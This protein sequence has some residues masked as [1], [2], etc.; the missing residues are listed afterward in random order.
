MYNGYIGMGGAMG[1]WGDRYRVDKSTQVEEYSVE[2]DDAGGL[3]WV[4]VDYVAA[5]YGVAD[6]DS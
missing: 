1:V 3:E 6:L 4:A 5:C 2:D